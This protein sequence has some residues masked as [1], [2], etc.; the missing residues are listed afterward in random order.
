MP[1]GNGAG[2][3]G[4]AGGV[5]GAG[6]SK[7]GA[8]GGGGVGRGGRR[9]GG[10]GRAGGVGN[11]NVGGGFSSGGGGF[12]GAGG[13]PG[14]P[15]IGGTTSGQAVAEAAGIGRPERPG[16]SFGDLGKSVLGGTLTAG[17]PGGVVAGIANV[18]EQAL[19]GAFGTIDLDSRR[20]AAAGLED[21]SGRGR[22]PERSGN[23]QDRDLVS[24]LGRGRATGDAQTGPQKTNTGTTGQ[25]QVG[26]TRRPVKAN[27][28]LSIGLANTARKTLLGV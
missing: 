23:S 5:G 18:A 7:G 15:S 12:G 13:G 9:G 22:G 19:G 24:L 20:Q 1:H 17:I 25:G 6:T 3:G 14:Q 16:F 2:P 11:A 28:V 4:R 21:A 27:S 8:S 26:G 10:R